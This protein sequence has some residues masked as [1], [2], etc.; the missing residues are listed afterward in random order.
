MLPVSSFGN[1]TSPDLYP[2]GQCMR[3][4]SK[5]SSCKSFNDFFNADRTSSGLCLVFHS[6]DV[7]KTSSRFRPYKVKYNIFF[8]VKLDTSTQQHGYVKYRRDTKREWKFYKYYN[9]HELLSK[10]S[11]PF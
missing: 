8:E 3:Y 1:L 4:K 6:F 5:Y 7:T 9:Y 2:I 11:T 10:Q